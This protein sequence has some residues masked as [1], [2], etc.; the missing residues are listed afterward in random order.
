MA[1][2]RNVAFRLPILLVLL[3]S[4][5]VKPATTS[6]LQSQDV[7]FSSQGENTVVITFLP[8]VVSESNDTTQ[9][10]VYT[11]MRLQGCHESAEPGQPVLPYRTLFLALPPG[12]R[13]TWQ[14]VQREFKDINEC[15]IAPAMADLHDSVATSAAA[16][17][18][19]VQIID[20]F[21]P[22]DVCQTGAPDWLRKMQVA[23]VHLYPM[24]Y[25]KT[26]HILRLYKKLTI[27]FN[28]IS[29]SSSLLKSSLSGQKSEAAFDPLLREKILNYDM[30]QAWRP[31]A[32]VVS[33]SLMNWPAGSWFR[34]PLAEDGFYKVTY[35]QLSGLYYDSLSVKPERMGI[36][37][38]G[39]KVRPTG[40]TELQ[41]ETRQ[42]T[43]EFF[44]AN[45]DGL[46]GKCD[47]LLFYG[48]AT[49]GWSYDPEQ[50]QHSHY[51]NPFTNQNV[52][53]LYIGAQPRRHMLRQNSIDGFV[54][55]PAKTNQ[56][57]G[58]IFEEREIYN[59]EKSG[60]HWWWDR[61]T[62]TT[63]GKYPVPLSWPVE[64]ESALLRLRVK[65]INEVYH[66]FSF[67]INN[68]LLGN[69]ELP[70]TL[71][72]IYSWPVNSIL[73]DGE[74][75]LKISQRS[76][77]VEKS[78][79]VFDWYELEYHKKLKTEN[80]RLEF[81]S[82]KRDQ[83]FEYQIN[84]A[85]A[86]WT[87][88][89]VS[90]PFNVRLMQ[91][92]LED[93]TLVFQDSS[94]ATSGGRHYLLVGQDQIRTVSQPQPIGNTFPN[95]GN[96]ER[97]AD[98]VII[99]APEFKGRALDQLADHRRDGRFWPHQG[100]PQVEIVT[101]TEIYD[102]FSGGLIDPTALR[103]FLRYAYYHW[104]VA[105]SYVLLVGDACFDIKNNN[106]GSPRT[107]IP[108]Y[109]EELV[110]SDDWFVCMEDDQITDMY[111][112]RLP[113]HNQ[114]ELATV[115]QKIITYDTALPAGPWKNSLLM[116]AD[117]EYSPAYTYED[118][119]FCR[120][121]EIMA[122]DSCSSRF[123]VQK[124]YL[125]QYSRN[126]FGKKPR[127][128]QALL[129]GIN[130]GQ[131]YINFL[132]HGNHEVLTHEDI[133]NSPD[134]MGSLLNGNRLPLFF[135][136]T[137]AVGQFDYDRKNSMAEELILRENGGCF[138]V[139]ASTRWN[140][141]SITSAIN[142]DFYRALFAENGTQPSLGQALAAAKLNSRY[143]E[144]RQ[145]LVLFGDPAQRLAVPQLEIQCR[146]LPD[147]LSLTKNV[148]IKGTINQ[149]RQ[150]A[151][152]FS[153][154]LF[155][156]F[157]ENT[158]SQAEMGYTIKTN[159]AVLH[160]DTLR[161]ERGVIDSHIQL[162]RTS[163]LGG[164][165]GK[166]VAYAWEDQPTSVLP[167]RDGS[168]FINNLLIKP[169]TLTAEFERDQT[170][171]N[172]AIKVNDAPVTALDEITVDPSFHV[173]F[174]LKDKQSGIYHTNGSDFAITL[175]LDHSSDS[176]WDVTSR[177]QADSGDS[178]NGTLPFSFENLSVGKHDL[179][180]T[181]WDN[182][183]NKSTAEWTIDVAANEFTLKDLLNYP[184]PASSQTSFTFLLTRDARVSI[185]IYTVSGRLI[186]VFEE[187]GERGFNQL[188][189]EGWDCRD[190]DGDALA[191]GVYLYKVT[192]REHGTEF[193]A[194]ENRTIESAGRLVI[195]R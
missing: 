60:Y 3:S 115:V 74:N 73:H 45:G 37:Y 76:T 62:G 171:P 172:I 15:R 71:E 57:V 18:T 32:A 29:G 16:F 110:A 11:K 150:T 22:S 170:G 94:L 192:A 186:K 127:V 105:P 42:V 128:K 126:A 195:M 169:D 41:P 108:A 65:G 51:T 84:G 39:G 119:V 2:L 112:G 61:L 181:V 107:F 49:S 36:Y 191:N 162:N 141:H 151:S 30:A 159:G 17:D 90:D 56:A 38:G 149:G 130:Q 140:A 23:A 182:A 163:T 25:H 99:T 185:K 161:I 116:V 27:Q 123:D 164:H 85:D 189:Q 86:S 5:P 125:T 52:Y 114:Q 173:N 46:F 178:K 145:L 101:T 154:S 69:A 7:Q 132:G 28:I 59:D 75:E 100:Q 120:D 9:G 89:E 156:K 10:V 160:T 48:Q 142:Q 91:P 190:E 58:R 183:L 43:T 66:N 31:P 122:M 152:D 174:I 8:R 117:D 136:G 109:E 1:T 63:E 21:F 144:H 129:D 77:G 53:W 72:R 70:Y 95:L 87:V 68:Q 4:L 47:H 67:S 138:A 13:I 124:L 64:N 131:L 133:L 139:I 19:T 177:F 168:G 93:T 96:P 146:T 134:D 175:Q 103:N 14:I 167:G 44:D 106:G 34:I 111:I 188:P 92:R 157:Y 121:S 143:P 147:T 81:W 12:G 26:K 80:G 82:E 194:S 35:E 6:G 179:S 55:H 180:M 155:V 187:Y 166:M 113:V 83:V 137:C 158:I 153:G 20:G 165:S 79:I 54:P 118:N 98:Y 193:L 24:Q 88:A 33:R 176:L 104:R 148:F 97:G 184:N 135:A 50:R 40:A 102:E 78:Q